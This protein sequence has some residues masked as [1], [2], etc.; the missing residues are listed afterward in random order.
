MVG[1]ESENETESE[2]EVS[3]LVPASAI[4]SRLMILWRLI[5]IKSLVS[6]DKN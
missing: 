6:D 2:E 1:S 3:L 4:A 5:I